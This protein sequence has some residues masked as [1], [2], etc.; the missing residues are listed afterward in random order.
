MQD[1]SLVLWV[2][3][4]TGVTKGNVLNGSGVYPAV[5]IRP[6]ASVVIRL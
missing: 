1:Y 4:V 2:K 3:N 5:M 6:F